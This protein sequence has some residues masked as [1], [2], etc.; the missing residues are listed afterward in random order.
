MTLIINGKE[1][2]YTHT[3]LQALLSEL[4]YRA[5]NVA[6]AVNG[7]FISKIQRAHITLEQGDEIEILAP[8]QG[9]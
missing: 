7:V 5:D 2:P 6:T 1:Q 9:G 8:M 4:G 3:S